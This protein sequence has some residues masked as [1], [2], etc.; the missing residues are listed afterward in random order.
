[1]RMMSILYTKKWGTVNRYL[2]LL[3]PALLIEIFLFNLSSVRTFYAG[4]G[5]ELT[6]MISVSGEAVPGGESGS[7]TAA[8]ES[9]SISMDH[10]NAEVENI[11]I[12]VDFMA[13]AVPVSIILTDEG[14]SLPY[15]LPVHYLLRGRGRTDSRYVTLHPYG[16]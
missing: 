11:Y 5:A 15:G 16:K 10:L 3:I 6:D 9:F 8:A 12:D 7:Y 1:M 14:N 13:P 2:R 4:E